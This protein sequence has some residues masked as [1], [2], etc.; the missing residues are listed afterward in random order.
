[1]W[2]H[3]NL[4]HTCSLFMLLYPTYSTDLARRLHLMWCM[5]LP[6]PKLPYTYTCFLGGFLN[7]FQQFFTFFGTS[8]I[9]IF[10]TYRDEIKTI[11]TEISHPFEWFRS[12]LCRLGKLLFSTFQKM[13]K[14]GG[15]NLE[16]RLVEESNQC[17]NA[18]PNSATQ[19]SIRI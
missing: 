8:K 15:T 12:R 2:F 19:L 11:R 3:H 18:S 6:F 17:S 4:C 5:F 1:M 14:M 10:P 7:S 13:R 9:A 16:T